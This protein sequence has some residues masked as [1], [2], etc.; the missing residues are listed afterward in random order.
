[1]TCCCCCCFT[2]FLSHYLALY[3]NTFADLLLDV[4]VCVCVY[5]EGDVVV[6]ADEDIKFKF[7]VCRLPF[8]F[9]LKLFCQL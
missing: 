3:I 9:R 1:M 7:A 4:R 2:P 5:G 6:C 8:A